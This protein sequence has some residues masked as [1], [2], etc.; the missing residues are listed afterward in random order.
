MKLNWNIKHIGMNKKK[1][2]PILLMLF[3]GFVGVYLCFNKVENSKIL[4]Q[5]NYESGEFLAISV[6][7]EDKKSDLWMIDTI[8][9][10]SQKLISD[11]E[12]MIS[13]RVNKLGDKLL[14]SD[15]PGNNSW[16]I[17]SLNITNSEV[18]QITD[19]QFGEF[20]LAFGDEIGNIILSKSG[21]KTSPIPRISIINIEKNSGDFIELDDGLGVQDFDIR[22]NNV[23]ILAFKYEEFID[24]RFKNIN[25][26]SPITYSIIEMN[27]ESM[28]QKIVAQFDAVQLD[29]IS[30]CSSGEEVMISGKGIVNEDVGFYKLNIN[31]NRLEELLGQKKLI[32]LNKIQSFCQPYKAILSKDNNNLYFIGTPIKAKELDVWG[33][34]VYS[35][36]LYKY[37]FK[38][39][40]LTE[41][42]NIPNT[43]ISSFSL[44]Y[45]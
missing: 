44:T 21:G 32:E 42:F 15:A 3:I 13:G 9:N 26:T 11:R 25:D 37:N 1:N 12:V 36:I 27:L 7:N 35:N 6:V 5:K 34:S 33:M 16:D 24:K 41:V 39:K 2:K 38:S 19:D 28:E 17:F 22:D 40:E 4:T 10:T 43:F 14:F 31:E 29:S 23:I 8:R 18:Y 20:N 45:K 30:Y